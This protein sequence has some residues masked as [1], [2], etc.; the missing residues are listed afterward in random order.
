MHSTLMFVFPLSP[1]WNPSRRSI[2]P[3]TALPLPSEGR[4]PVTEEGEKMLALELICRRYAASAMDGYVQ[5]AN[6]LLSRTGIWKVQ[7][8]AI[9][10]KEKK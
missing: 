3:G 7:V 6:R 9:T 5:E 1:G 4:S 2:P 10:G 8:E